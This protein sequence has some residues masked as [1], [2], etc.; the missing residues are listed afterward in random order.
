VRDLTNLSISGGWESLYTNCHNSNIINVKTLGTN[1]A[2]GVKT[3]ND[4]MDIIGG[5]NVHVSKCFL[6]GHDDCYCLKSQKFK[7]K[8]DVD[9]IWY[10]DCIGWNVDAGNTFEIGYETNVDIRNVHYR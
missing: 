9:G 8:G 10:E 2:P 1:S 6:Y 7:L 5:I 3:N 4:S